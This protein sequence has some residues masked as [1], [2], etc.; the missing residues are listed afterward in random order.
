MMSLGEHLEADL[1]FFKAHNAQDQSPFP[2][3]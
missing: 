2:R 3:N 1:M